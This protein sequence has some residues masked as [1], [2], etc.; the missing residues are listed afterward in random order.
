[1]VSTKPESGKTFRSTPLR[2]GRR[3]SCKPFGQLRKASSAREHGRRGGGLGRGSFAPAAHS[4]AFRA[5]YSPREAPVFLG[6][7]CLSRKPDPVSAFSHN[8]RSIEIGG[9]LGAYVLNPASPIRAE[10]VIAH[11]V[12]APVDDRFEARLQ[13][14]P[15]RRIDLDL[16]DRILHAL[17]EIAASLGDP[18]PSAVLTS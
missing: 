8:E 13:R 14:R 16:E 6:H 17:P 10:I 12:L 4:D 2:E 7:A 1:M 11:A 15:L 5:P 3:L 18:P 9:R